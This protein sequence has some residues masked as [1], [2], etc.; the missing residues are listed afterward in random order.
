MITLEFPLKHTRGIRW[1]GTKSSIK[2]G[3]KKV[4]PSWPGSLDSAPYFSLIIL[5]CLNYS[6]IIFLLLVISHG[7]C[8][9]WDALGTIWAG[10]HCLVE[11]LLSHCRHIACPLEC[12]RMHY[13]SVRECIMLHYTALLLVRKLGKWIMYGKLISLL[14]T[15]DYWRF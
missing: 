11:P 3:L 14:T 1:E 2:E 6:L 8:V 5:F 12:I 9:R 4:I 7:H 10:M 15:G 13:I